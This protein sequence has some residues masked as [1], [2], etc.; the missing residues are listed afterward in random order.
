MQNDKENVKKRNVAIITGTRAEYGILKPLL[1]KIRRED[2]L[3][4]QLIVTGMHLLKKYGMTVQEI[5][6]DGWEI[7]VAVEMYKGKMDAYYWSRGLARGITNFAAAFLK[8]KSDIVIVFGDR[9]EPFAAVLAASSLKIPIVHIHGGDKTDSGHIDENIRH[10]ITRFSHIHLV[11]T[12]ICKRRLIK[13]GEEPWRVYTVGALNIDSILKNLSADA[14][15]LW[16][17]LN[18]NPGKK[19]IVCLFNPVDIEADIMGLQMREIA[20]ALEVLQE[21]TVIIYPNNDKGSQD[22]I[23]EIHKIKHLPF[24]RVCVNLPH[25][26]FLQLLKHAHV[27]IGNSSS[28]IIEAPS[29]KLAVINIGSRNVGREH[30]S[31]IT[32]VK[33]RKKAIQDAIQKALV[34]KKRAYKNPYGSGFAS[35]KIMEVISATRLGENVLRKKITY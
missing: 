35:D 9:L 29:L 5:Q 33:A 8:L 27:L 19:I 26:E 28:G 12:R 31:N 20:H 1:E 10:A 21:Q 34:A 15:Q 13:M 25:E 32:F 11:P 16:K 14:D 7:Q 30:A 3:R 17:K 24:I 6:K 2:G 23:A 4:L 18:L 22:I